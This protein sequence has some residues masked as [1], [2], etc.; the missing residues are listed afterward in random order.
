MW[1]WATW[2]RV[3]QLIDLDMSDWNDHR[4]AAFL[5]DNYGAPWTTELEWQRHFDNTVNRNVDT[6]DYQVCYA[7][8]RRG[9]VSIAPSVNL[10]DNDGFSSDATHP[11][12]G[13]PRCLLDSPPQSMTFPLRHPQA[14]QL[15]PT[16]DDILD[17]DAFG[18]SLRRSLHIMAKMQLRKVRHL[19]TGRYA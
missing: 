5:K 15:H 12:S 11:Q 2:R 1:G 4:S 13:K 14:V 18:I 3:W 7:L 19:L 16:A 6:W 8:W 9:M 17:R 10:I